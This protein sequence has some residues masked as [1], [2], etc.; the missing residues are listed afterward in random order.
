MGEYEREKKWGKILTWRRTRVK[1]QT[2]VG[3][4]FVNVGGGGEGEPPVQQVVLDLRVVQPVY[5][6]QQHSYL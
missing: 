1:V 6:G 3:K 4:G 5:P 2:E